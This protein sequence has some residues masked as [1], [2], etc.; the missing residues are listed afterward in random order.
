LFSLEKPFDG[1]P[2]TVGNGS[3]VAFRGGRRSVVDAAY[4]VGLA[5]GGKGDGEPA[6]KE[7]DPHYYAA[8]LRD[9]EGNKIEVVTFAAD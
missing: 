7:Y 3:H 2:A 4:R 9:P 5:N 8:F 6:V 1:R